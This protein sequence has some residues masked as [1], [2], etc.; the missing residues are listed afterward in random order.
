MDSESTARGIPFLTTGIECSAE[1]RGGGR[2]VPN[3]QRPGTIPLWTA[4]ADRRGPAR[5]RSRPAKGG[6]RRGIGLRSCCAMDRYEQFRRAAIDQG[7]PEDEA[8]KFAAHLRFE[9]RLGSGPDEKVVAQSGGLPRLPVGMEWAGLR[10]RLLVAVHRLDR[11]RA[12]PAGGRAAPAG[13]R[14]SCRRASSPRGSSRS[15]RTGSR[16]RTC[17]SNRKR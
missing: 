8:A 13:R 5:R 9:I 7:L 15:C 3:R 4:T 16:R 10:Q 6:P 17:D 1:R 11:L 14:S 2:I 12:R